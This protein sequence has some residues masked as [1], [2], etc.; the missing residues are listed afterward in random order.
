[1]TTKRLKVLIA[2]M[3]IIL[4]FMLGFNAWHGENVVTEMQ[5]QPVVETGSVASWEVNEVKEE[6]TI[7]YTWE[8][9]EKEIAEKLNSLIG[10]Y[11]IS[12][13]IVHE[14]SLQTKDY[15]LCIKNV[16]WVANAESSMFKKWMYP[17]NNGFGWM[18]KGKKRKFSSVEESI[19]Q[20]VAMYVRN[21]WANRT[22]WKARLNWK[23]CT[24]SCSNWVSAYN[25]AV[26][27]V[28]KLELW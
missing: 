15:K 7:I 6:E 16:L 10:D 22:T 18:Y 5:V 14:C 2:V 27:K 1:M 17:S 13:T 11:N 26:K 21:G 28:D 24:S 20:W 9:T 23:Y 12:Y 4:V 25:S 8:D 19:K 3:T